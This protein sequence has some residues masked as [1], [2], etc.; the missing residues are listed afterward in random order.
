[1]AR[2][3]APAIPQRLARRRLDV[4]R[5]AQQAC[6]AVFAVFLWLFVLYPMLQVL[7]RSLHDNDG[8]LVG[9]ANYVRYVRT[10]AIAASIT[11]SLIVSAAAMVINVFLAFV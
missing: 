4:E 3:L 6:V 1:M 2:E 5:V 9:V 8:R 10:P 11:N 7:W